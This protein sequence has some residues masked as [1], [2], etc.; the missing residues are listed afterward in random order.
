MAGFGYAGEILKVD[1]SSRRTTSL[2]TADYVDRFLG[3]RGIAAKLYRDMF[4]PEARA[5]DPENCI[6][7]ATGPVAGFPGFAGGRWQVCEKSTSTDPEAFSYASLGERWGIRL[8]Y[9]GFEGVAIQGKSDKPVYIYIHNGIVEIKA[10]TYLW[11]KS[12]YET[13]NCLKVEL[14]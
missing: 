12:A 7:Y 2:F 14:G 3:G 1:L 5:L 6:I 11:G 4:S 10:A 13:C 8:K 9:A